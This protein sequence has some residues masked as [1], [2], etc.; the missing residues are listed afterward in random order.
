M[1]GGVWGL[2]PS[3]S[4]VLPALG[5]LWLPHAHTPTGAAAFQTFLVIP[6]TCLEAEGT[7]QG[8][9]GGAACCILEQFQFLKITSCD[10]VLGPRNNVVGPSWSF[11]KNK[12]E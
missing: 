12:R 7:H 2:M 4:S 10:L 9:G 6:S 8:Q 5:D 3:W 11:K 1:L